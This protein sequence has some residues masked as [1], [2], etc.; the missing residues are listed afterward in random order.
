MKKKIIAVL[1]ALFITLSTIVPSI[2]LAQDKN[3]TTSDKKMSTTDAN[4][5][6]GTNFKSRG[7]EGNIIDKNKKMQEKKIIQKH[8]KIIIRIMKI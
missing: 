6:V 2:V 8:L 4:N 7:D 1:L 5:K 3:D